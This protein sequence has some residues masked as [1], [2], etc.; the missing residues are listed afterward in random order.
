MDRDIDL[1][2]AY[3]LIE[4]DSLDE[5]RALLRE[6]IAADPDNPDGYWLLAHAVDDPSEARTALK[7]LMALDP[8]YPG[9]RDLLQSLD[10]S[11]A[12]PA[13]PKTG[14]TRLPAKSNTALEDDLSFDIEDEDMV[15]LAPA[16]DFDFD[17]EEDDAPTRTARLEDEFDDEFEDESPDAMDSAGANRRRLLLAAFTALALILA[18]VLIFVI[19]P[20]RPGPQTPDP[21][22]TQISA[23]ATATTPP[24]TPP[25]VSFDSFYTALSNVNVV[26]DSGIIENTPYGNTLALSVCVESRRELTTIIPETLRALAAQAGSAGQAVDAIGARFINC[27]EGNVQLRYIV[28]TTVDALEFASGALSANDFNTRLQVVSP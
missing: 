27:A 5:A 22:A 26:P 12:L 20:F 19:N 16:G 3:E 25:D 18:I 8:A 14:I 17:L 4:A 23:G 21:A 10:S 9:A 13:Q 6:I 2:R 1:Q 7:R 28:V 11:L 15:D 24:S